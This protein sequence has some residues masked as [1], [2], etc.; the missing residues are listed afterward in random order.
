[1]LIINKKCSNLLDGYK[2]ALELDQKLKTE[3]ESK[4]RP[5]L[6]GKLHQIET[7]QTKE[8]QAKMLAWQ[9]SERVSIAQWEEEEKTRIAEWESNEILN[10]SIHFAEKSQCIHQNQPK[11]E[12]Q[13]LERDQW[14]IA[15]ISSSILSLCFFLLIFP[16]GKIIFILGFLG[17]LSSTGLLGFAVAAFIVFIIKASSAAKPYPEY[18]PAPKPQPARRVTQSIPIAPNKVE[19]LVD[20]YSCPN[21]ISRWME[22]IQYNDNG[23]EYFRTFSLDN[24]EAINGIPGEIALLNE[25]FA[26]NSIADQVI[27][28]PGLKTGTRGD[29]D[30]ISISCKGL[31]ILE[32]KYFTGKVSFHNGIWKH[33]VYTKHNGQ[34]YL[35]DWEEKEFQ[36]S[37]DPVQQLINSMKKIRN[38]LSDYFKEN[39]WLDEVIKGALVFT[40]PDVDLDISNCSVPYGNLL[41]LFDMYRNTLNIP[42]LTFEKQ[43]EIADILLSK[44]HEIEESNISTV[45]I[46]VNIYNQ[47]IEYLGKLV[48]N[49]NIQ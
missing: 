6:L 34:S 48:S 29:I 37:F 31:W 45:Q 16:L 20:K 41:D 40:H 43:L 4:F 9:E 32:S 18:V 14:M 21:I 10:K 38:I 3:W 24:P 1:M 44:D 17:A 35:N 8:Y 42:E 12:Q 11:I 22:E 13:K 27:Y 25:H 39:P 19:N 15:W 5:E 23:K 49:H 36:K 47:S 7:E 2:R 33:L 30:G 46:A 26:F 28:I